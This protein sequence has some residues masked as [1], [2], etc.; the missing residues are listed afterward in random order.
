MR[1]RTRARLRRG[2]G[3]LFLFLHET[4]MIFLFFTPSLSK[5]KKMEFKNTR[6]ATLP[7]DEKTKG[8]IANDQRTRER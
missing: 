6:V 8:G 5:E 2:C 7:R 4:D 1:P 3:K